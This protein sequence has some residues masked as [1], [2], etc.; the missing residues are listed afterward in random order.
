M[1]KGSGQAVRSHHVALSVRDVEATK[2]FYELFGFEE[3]LRVDGPVTFIH[4]AGVDGFVLELFCYAENSAA[5][6][7]AGSAGNDLE[8]IGVKHLGLRVDDVEAVRSRLM[9]SGI[10]GVTKVRRGVADI[11]YFF[12]ADPDGIWVEVLQVGGA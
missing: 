4:L 3:V 12:V 7:L 1:P 10:E 2:S 11:D 9:A 6:A 8:R 5:P